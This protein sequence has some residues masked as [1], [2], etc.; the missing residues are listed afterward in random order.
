[1]TATDTI[2]H[3]RLQLNTLL[4]YIKIMLTSDSIIMMNGKDLQTEI[5]ELNRKLTACYIKS[6]HITSLNTT[7]GQI[8]FVQSE[9]M[10]DCFTLNSNG[11]VIVGDD[12][13]LVRVYV[14]IGCASGSGG[15]AWGYLKHNNNY[16]D[17]GLEYGSYAIIK[18]FGIIQ[19]QKGDTISAEFYETSAISSAGLSCTMIVEKII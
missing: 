15:R 17:S 14:S 8:P 3:I 16:I 2:K 13:E 19:V 4:G 5:N 7:E 1:M 11:S 18:L 9:Q 10:G 12:V 6:K